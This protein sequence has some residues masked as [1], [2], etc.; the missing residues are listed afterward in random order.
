MRAYYGRGG[1][2]SRDL[3]LSLSHLEQ[4]VEQEVKK[5][6]K[7]VPISEPAKPYEPVQT[8]PA[9]PVETLPQYGGRVLQKEESPPAAPN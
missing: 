9:A 1:E 8:E 7:P 5:T 6:D 4:V 3:F 2:A